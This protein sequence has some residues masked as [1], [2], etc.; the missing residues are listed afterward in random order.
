MG[1][2]SLKRKARKNRVVAKRRNQ[3]IKLN[4]VK[5]VVKSVDV[6]KIKEEFEAAASKKSSAKKV[7]KVADIVKEEIKAEEQQNATKAT[8]TAPKAEKQEV[9]EKDAKPTPKAEKKET[10]EKETKAAPKA[11]K[12]EVEEKKE[13][14]KTPSK[15]KGKEE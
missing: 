5:P 11:E 13:A 7:D 4:T 10:E 1:A 14:K 9:E 3:A 15:S 12:K 2:T 6:E 8:E